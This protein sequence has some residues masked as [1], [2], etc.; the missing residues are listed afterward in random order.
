MLTEIKSDDFFVE[1]EREEAENPSEPVMDE[2]YP[3]YSSYGMMRSLRDITGLVFLADFGSARRGSTEQHGWC[4]PDTYRAPEVLMGVPWGFQ[5][6]VWSI[7]LMVSIQPVL[8]SYRALLKM[9]QALELIQGS[10]LFAPIDRTHKQ[11]V[12]PLALAQHISV[13]GPP[14]L[15]M[16]QETTNPDIAA[17][18][19]EQGKYQLLDQ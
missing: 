6:D 17:F 9:H 7:G 3:V 1:L 12:L 5:V 2:D 18:F 13:L 4:M 15:W 19:D 14:P 16:I 10:S 11:Y 8:R